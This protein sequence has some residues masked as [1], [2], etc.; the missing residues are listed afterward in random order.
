[1]WE[2]LIVLVIA[3]VAWVRLLSVETENR[4]LR[5]DLGS[6]REEIQALRQAFLKRISAL[7]ENVVEPSGDVASQPVAKP[8][9]DGEP[10]H[11][12]TPVP[13]VVVE[14]PAPV[15]R[16]VAEA[17][18]PPPPPA[19]PFQRPASPKP[20]KLP[21]RINWE[22][23]V[24][25]RG[26]AVLGA[27]VLG[28]AAVLFL[29]YSIES[30]LI[31]PALRVAAGFIAGA[32]AVAASEWL[33]K[34]SYSTQADALAGGGVII[35]YAATWAAR[36][37]YGFI[38]SVT[39]GALMVLITVVCGYLAWRHRA[40]STALLGLLGGFATPLLH[41]TGQDR[42]ITLFAYLLMLNVGLYAL[43]RARNWPILSA[44]AM[45]VTVFYQAGWIFTRMDADRS[46]LGLCVLGVFAAFYVASVWAQGDR[47]SS[48]LEKWARA[49]GVVTPF[50]FA[51]YFAASVELSPHLFPL[52]GLLALLSLA[53]AW[54]G[55][56]EEMRILPVVAAAADV[57]IVTAWVSQT[58]F[59]TARSWE[60][61]V[62]MILFAAAFHA[63][64]EWFKRRDPVG[65]HPSFRVPALASAACLALLLAPTSGFNPAMGFVAWLSALTVLSLLLIRQDSL[66]EGIRGTWAASL[67]IGVGFAIAI[68]YRPP[69]GQPPQYWLYLLALIFSA[70]LLL[71]G[72]F[73]SDLV[74]K[75]SLLRAAVVAPIVIALG[76]F[77]LA[78]ALHV[79][80]IFFLA[81][82]LLLGVLLAIAAEQLRHGGVLT[83]AACL[84]AI[85]HWLWAIEV[86]RSTPTG[87][88]LTLMFAS[89]LLFTAWPLVLPA[90]RENRWALRTSAL[91][92]PLW[93]A[94]LYGPYERV[95]GD[96]Y[97]A[98]LPLV[99]ATVAA[100]ALVIYRGLPLIS[101][102]SKKHA[103]VWYAAVALS[104]IAL[105]IPLQLEKEWVL[106]G[107][108]IQ[109]ALLIRLW[110]KL[111]H[112]GLKYFALSLLAVVTVWLLLPD[113]WAFHSRSG[114]PILNWLM[115][116]Y[117]VPA[118][119][120]I[121]SA[122]GLRAYEVS[123]ARGWETPFYRGGQP[124][125]AGVCGFAGI[126]VTFVWINLTVLD[127]FSTGREI[128]FGFE[129]MAAR[130]LTL[131]F[132]WA[133]FALTLLGVGFR[134][135]IRP[136]RWVSLAFLLV[137]IGKVFLYDLGELDDLYRVASLVGLAL[138]LI[139]V[140]LAYQRFV[141]SQKSD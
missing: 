63:P 61:A 116:T 49:A 119:A 86:S 23:W 84:V 31:S 52:A 48:P 77:P 107:W 88:P 75:I 64:W 56:D 4:R 34:K 54:L 130:D 46:W 111:D 40:L 123:R 7:E 29:Q 60:L 19:P 141:F 68:N 95:F 100:A 87:G 122:I 14:E 12:A 39:A 91:A 124:I 27:A 58:T 110:Q 139:L 85:L 120:L 28:L 138:S 90:L 9:F 42:P 73:E 109:G 79:P 3:G 105:A 80:D 67:A 43:S 15:A 17:L 121:A 89:V 20:Q 117:L 96:G 1:V 125:G 72:R 127:V 50:G 53:T 78:D 92:G 76:M 98:V 101:D 66:R 94:A 113:A 22:Q 99:L 134:T 37:L 10:E 103:A 2:I 51:A 24:G 65:D 82:A 137:T 33:R 106:I 13:E 62:A 47:T 25:V 102:A 70:A 71:P 118:A 114:Q 30:G 135:K 81:V 36:I 129:R 55:R 133:L 11:S 131:S 93:F 16:S 18:T 44:L 97:P 128:D 21:I 74:R 59:D 5:H 35:L 83:L 69:S 115:Y 6:I 26:A 45:L 140:S 57:G 132:A 8:V 104:F 41:S 136:L 112:P 126:L 32:L 38:G 108:A